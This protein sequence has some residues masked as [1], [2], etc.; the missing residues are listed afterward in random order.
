MGQWRDLNFLPLVQVGSH[1]D[2]SPHSAQVL[3]APAEKKKKKEI[4]KFL[5]NKLLLSMSK[6][7]PIEIYAACIWASSFFL[8]QPPPPR[9]Q[10]GTLGHFFP[11][12]F[13]QDCQITVL[14]A[15]NCHKESWQALN[16]FLTKENAQLNF[17]FH[18]IS[19]PNH[20]GKGLDPPKIKQMPI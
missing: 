11:G 2:Q 17:N 13:E 7:S 3:A 4:D 1:S 5:P 8:L 12:R 14:G 10:T 9:T 15:N 6:G 19:A 20:P 16:P 18:C